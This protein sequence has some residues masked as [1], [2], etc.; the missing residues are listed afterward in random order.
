MGEGCGV[1]IITTDGK[2][3]HTNYG[4]QILEEELSQIIPEI[5]E[6]IHFSPHGTMLEGWHAEYMGHSRFAV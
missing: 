2:T 3:Y 6:G 1:V 4:G 5:K